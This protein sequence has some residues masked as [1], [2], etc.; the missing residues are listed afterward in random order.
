MMYAFNP[1]CNVYTFLFQ[2]TDEAMTTKLDH[3]LSLKRPL[4]VDLSSCIICQ[5]GGNLRTATP[6]GLSTLQNAAKCRHRSRDTNNHDGNRKI[7]NS[8]YECIPK[9]IGFSQI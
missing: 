5:K 2:N 6:K 9:S 4:P 8:L 3:V 7:R 1:V